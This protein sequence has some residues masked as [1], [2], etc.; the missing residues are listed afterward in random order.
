[1]GTTKQQELRDKRRIENAKKR[2]TLGGLTPAQVFKNN[3][4]L[5][6][7]KVAANTL[8]KVIE[9]QKGYL[10]KKDDG[11]ILRLKKPYEEVSL[12]TN[13]AFYRFQKLFNQSIQIKYRTH[14][15]IIVFIF[16]NQQDR[17]EYFSHLINGR[18]V[19]VLN[20]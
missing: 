7:E 15:N 12:K 13:Q 10:Y 4:E 5:H 2:L 1:M 17:D 18:K 9:I 20:Q 19:K 14:R 3:Q 11:S 6:L 16:N 8:P